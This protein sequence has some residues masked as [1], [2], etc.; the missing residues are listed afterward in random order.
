MT[1]LGTF[2]WLLAVSLLAVMAYQI[3]SQTLYVSV[4]TGIYLDSGRAVLAGARPYIDFVDIN[5]PLAMYLHTPVVWVAQLLNVDVVAAFFVAIAA[6][7]VITSLWSFS[8]A[9]R[10]LSNDYRLVAFTIAL[11]LIFSFYDFHASWFGQREY[12]FVLALLPYMLLRTARLNGVAVSF[13]VSVICGLFIGLMASLKPPQFVA[14]LFAVELFLC[15]RHKSVRLLMTPEIA[16][17]VCVAVLYALIFF[18]FG[19]ASFEVF[20]ER[21]LPLFATSYDAMDD[22]AGMPIAK[23]I[24]QLGYEVTMSVIGWALIR[25]LAPSQ[26]LRDLSSIAL[27]TCL[28]GCVVY[29]SQAKGFGYHEIPIRYSANLIL[30][31]FIGLLAHKFL[32]RT[33]IAWDRQPYIAYMLVAFGLMG[34]LATQ[35]SAKQAAYRNNQGLVKLIMQQSLPG[36]RIALFG[37]TPLWYYPMLVQQDR[38]LGTRYAFSFMIP[39]LYEGASEDATVRHGYRVSDDR[40]EQERL[41]RQDIQNDITTLKPELLIIYRRDCLWCL[42]GLTMEDYL[43][44]QPA[45]FT[46][47]KDY[48]EQQS[49][50]WYLVFRRRVPAG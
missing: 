47:L 15:F 49:D 9:Q 18:L 22:P 6:A 10:L 43:L 16:V 28:M 38:Y 21:Y 36:N 45:E 13:Y 12:L 3:A 31:I 44:G 25:R 48:F 27:L 41:Y 5:P 23:L 1:K 34:I 40:V 24:S 33:S 17:A 29:V 30:C 14:L 39:M 11:T 50:D 46:F 26:V 42:Q 2:T 19:G 37:L 35:A 20:V 4:D 32:S 7:T 8:I